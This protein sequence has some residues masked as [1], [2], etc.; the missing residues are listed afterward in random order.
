MILPF[1][2]L[3]AP[4][5]STRGS[6]VQAARAAHWCA[7]TPVG[8][9]VVRH[10]EAGLLLRDRRLRQGSHAWP[11]MQGLEGAFAGFWTRSIIS[12]EGEPH[13]AL[14]RLARAALSDDYV[15]S[16]SDGFS[17]TARALLEGLRGEESFDFIERF[18][19]P[20]A[21]RAICRI[22]GLPD[23]EAEALGQ[24]ASALGLAMGPR[25]KE[26]EPRFNRATDVLM[27]LANRLITRVDSGE[28]ADSYVARL[29]HEARGMG[30]SDRQTLLDLVVISIFGGVDTTRAQLGFAVALFIEH[31]GQWQA[32]RENPGLVPQ[33]IDEVI[34]TWPTTTWSTREAVEDFEFGGVAFRAG[35]TVHV[36]VSA[37][38]RDPRITEDEDFDVTRRRKVHFGFGGGAHHCLGQFMARTDMA[39]ALE[40]LL[41]AWERIEWGGAP[42]YLP[43]SGNTSPIRLPI[44][45]VWG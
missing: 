35:E 15:L 44:R 19:E 22:L 38:G 37:T 20:F 25:A 17:G 34:R 39:R 9:A 24:N 28:D 2:D 27:D 21:A 16:L 30:I 33:A 13:K 45:P 26:F 7:R 5:F 11:D 29:V 23:G 8:L 41:E 12:Q 43:D 4:G 1:L 42:E 18:T 32:L 36:F 14:R 3:G 10:R 6:E 31:P 40:V